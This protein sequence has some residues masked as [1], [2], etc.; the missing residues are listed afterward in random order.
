[1]T[2]IYPTHPV[3]GVGAVVL[4]N[5]QILLEKRRNDPGRGKWS[6]PGG[7]V[8]LGEGLE[9]A[10]AR[11]VNEET[12]LTVEKMRLLDVVDAV[13]LDGKGAVKYHFV[14]IDYLVTVKEGDAVAASDAEELRWVRLDEVE[15]YELTDSF[16]E[17]FRKNK[18]ELASPFP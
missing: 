4:R 14:I 15:N 5:G 18:R 16:R 11:E 6:V 12:G 7:L 8:E 1:L 13:C 9:H 10:V 2:R 17:F 3:V